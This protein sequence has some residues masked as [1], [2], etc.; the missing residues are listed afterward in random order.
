M[1][2]PNYSLDLVPYRQFVFT[3]PKILRVYFRKDRRLLG[4]LRQSAYEALKAF[5]Q[6]AVNH[7]RAV[8]GVIIAI[9]TFGDLANFH[10]HLHAIATDGAFQS[11]G[12]FHVLPKIDLKRLEE[13]FRHWGL[14][15][16]RLKGDPF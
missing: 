11:T 2:H 1:F 6:A 12:W 7:R 5:L 13:L 3:I 9:Q 10:P 16:L 15:L 14:K 8:P 4:Q